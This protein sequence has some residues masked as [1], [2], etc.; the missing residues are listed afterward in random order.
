MKIVIAGGAGFI[1]SH[2]AKFWN[3]KNV[4]VVVIDSLKTGFEE[5][6]KDLSNVKL[7]KVSIEEKT[8]IKD[9]ILGSDYVYNL[10][11]MVSVPESIQK[12]EECISI[13]LNGYLNILDA[14]KASNIKKVILSSSAAVYGDNPELPK[15]IKMI[16]D[17]QT[18]MIIEDKRYLLPLVQSSMASSIKIDVRI[19]PS[20]S[21]KR[22]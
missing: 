17:K 6:L 1:G 12:M 20:I 4:E 19:N 16:M 21:E 8:K 2:L 11:A 10:A 18:E 14:S 15:T 22:I 13:N 3:D 5:N 9:I 7:Y